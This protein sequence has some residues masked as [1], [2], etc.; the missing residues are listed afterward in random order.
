MVSPAVLVGRRV[1]ADWERHQP[2][3]YN[4]AKRYD[5]RQEQPVAHHFVNGQA[6][7]KRV[8]K[9]ALQHAHNPGE[10]LLP[11]RLI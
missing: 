6:V 2:C 10:V 11:R 9:I 1:N 4:R 7:L 3:E 8:T 5:K